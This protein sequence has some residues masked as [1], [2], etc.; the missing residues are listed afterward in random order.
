MKREIADRVMDLALGCG[1]QEVKVVLMQNAENIIQIQNGKTEKMQ[2][3]TATSLAVNLFVD[4]RDG[5][6]YTNKLDLNSLESF[7]SQAAQTTRML[8]PDESRSLADPSRYYH[9]GGPDLKNFDSQLGEI[10]PAEK[11]AL[12][13]HNN[14]RLAGKDPRLISVESQYRDRQHQAYYL[15]SNGFQGKE[16]SS[17]CML[18]TIVTAQG[19]NGQHPMDGWGNTRIFYRDL[20]EEGIAEVALERTLRK[21]G[22]RPVNSG[23]Y[24][25]ILESPVAG[26]LLQP[27][28]NAMGGQA[29]QQRT[30][31]LIDRLGTEVASPLLNLIDD[32]LIP[33]T[34]GACHF[35]YDG[36]A[37]RRTPLF[38]KGVLLNYFIDTPCSKKLGL[39]PTTQGIHHLILE[40]G[41]LSLA[42]LM[43]EA[44]EAIMVTD[45]NGGNCD[46]ATGRFSYGIEGFLIKGGKIVQP[47]SG[48]NITGD[49]L[50]LWKNLIAISNDADPW[51]TVLIPSLLF[52]DVLF[53]GV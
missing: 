40:P 9:G 5:F 46:P 48:M 47:V 14:A 49:M 4:G 53:S 39:A 44:E 37:T 10:D 22:Q 27:I 8:E 28:L 11:R 20:P 52:K 13:Q 3:A 25:M 24:Q 43:Q 16:E 38:E 6:F 18:S 7:I 19:A 23:H 15:I 32:P 31:F 21:I 45:L 33:G 26:N 2:Q 29:L 17:Y 50:S 51:E 36:V 1:C 42:Q 35:D 41:P 30:S 34:R 12:A